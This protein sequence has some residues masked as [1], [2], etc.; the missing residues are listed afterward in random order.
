MKTSQN[1]EKILNDKQEVSLDF[2]NFRCFSPSQLKSFHLPFLLIWQ[3]MLPTIVVVRCKG[4]NFEG[5]R[6]RQISKISSI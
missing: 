6:P 1:L 5:C 3:P 2:Y 4:A